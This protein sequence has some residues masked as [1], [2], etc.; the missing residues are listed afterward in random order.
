MSRLVPVC[1]DFRRRENRVGD[2]LRVVEHRHVADIIEHDEP[3]PGDHL[4]G[5][6][7]IDIERKETVL[8]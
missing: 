8:A 7:A 2:Q 4:L 1:N 3:C 6:S 5:A